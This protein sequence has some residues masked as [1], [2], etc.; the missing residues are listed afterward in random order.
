M[1]RIMQFRKSH[2]EN[3]CTLK[4]EQ[5]RDMELKWEMS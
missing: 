5:E 3:G 4:L 2:I 1:T